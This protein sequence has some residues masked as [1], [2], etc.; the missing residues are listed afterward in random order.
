MIARL[1]KETHQY[2][3]KSYWR[4]EGQ[5]NK[6]A[7]QNLDEQL[8]STKV[9]LCIKQRI[10]VAA[11]SFKIIWCMF[12]CLLGGL[13]LYTECLKM[14]VSTF[15]YD[16]CYSTYTIR[17]VIALAV[18]FRGCARCGWWV[19]RGGLEAGGCQDQVSR[20]GW[21]AGLCCD[22]MGVGSVRSG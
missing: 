16:C 15:D 11:C 3:L 6:W 21:D 7:P 20:G 13:N 14:H 12:E 1:L 5:G 4:R 22:R 8:Y 9:S 19:G 18:S 10:I 17:C 2:Q